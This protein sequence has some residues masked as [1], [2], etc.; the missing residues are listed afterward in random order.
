[1]MCVCVCMFVLMNLIKKILPF[2]LS[3]VDK[4]YVYIS[5][6]ASLPAN[7]DAPIKFYCEDCNVNFNSQKQ[8]EQHLTSPKHLKRVHRH[9]TA[10]QLRETMRGRGSGQG[11]G[12]GGM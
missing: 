2:S 11:R 6:A 3:E 4:K 8:L 12:R 1:M 10:E 9:P 5:E 7:G